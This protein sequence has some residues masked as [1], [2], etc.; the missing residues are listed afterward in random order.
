[1][2]KLVEIECAGV[3]GSD[4]RLKLLADSGY[5][6][7]PRPAL[8]RM[9]RGQRLVTVS[10]VY[11]PLPAVAASRRQPKPAASSPA[12]VAAT[13]PPAFRSAGQTAAWWRGH[14]D[15]QRAATFSNPYESGRGGYRNA[16][17]L[18]WQAAGRSL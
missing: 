2:N 9:D 14:H 1:M 10:I 15:A 7:G 5:I 3:V 16:Y 6:V 13:E 18:G 4:G 12:A 8:E 11:D 17:E